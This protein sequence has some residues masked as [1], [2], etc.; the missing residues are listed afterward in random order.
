M[1]VYFSCADVAKNPTRAE[2]TARNEESAET[3]R[4]PFACVP[5]KRSTKE[6]RLLH[7]IICT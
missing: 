1:H 7:K 5:P 2:T 3:R 4:G 6:I